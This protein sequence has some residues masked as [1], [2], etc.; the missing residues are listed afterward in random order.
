MESVWKKRMKEAEEWDHDN[1][2]QLLQHLPRHQE[3]VIESESI[4]E[5]LWYKKY[6]EK[7]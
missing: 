6:L 7:N 5:I 4:A 2:Q 3:V 1:K